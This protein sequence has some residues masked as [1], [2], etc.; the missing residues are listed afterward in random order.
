[1]GAFIMLV[2]NAYLTNSWNGISWWNFCWCPKP[3]NYPN[4]DISRVPGLTVLIVL[5][6]FN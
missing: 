1:M 5:S 4:R 6:I 2:I 3:N